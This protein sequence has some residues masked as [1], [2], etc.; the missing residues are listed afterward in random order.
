MMNRSML[1]ASAAWARVRGASKLV[2]GRGNASLVL[3]RAGAWAARR[4][5]RPG[6]A[7]RAHDAGW[8]GVL[9]EEE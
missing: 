4:A 8:R 9:G 3:I 7:R 2:R 6:R 1:A 5:R